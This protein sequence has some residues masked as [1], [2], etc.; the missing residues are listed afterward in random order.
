MPIPNLIYGTAWKQDRTADLVYTALRCGFRAIDS[1]AQ[2]QHYHE[3]GAGHG[4]RRA[5]AE[6]LVRR[7]HVFI[8]T[9]FTPAESQR[10]TAP[11]DL[12]AP[13]VDMVRQSV[14]SSLRSFTVPGQEPYLDSLFLHTP[15]K[16][17]Q[18]TVTVWRTLE[19]YVPHQIRSLGICNVTLDVIRALH[20]GMTVK[21][22]FVQNPLDK[23]RG[24]DADLRRFCRQRDMVF[25]SFWTLTANTDL[26]QSQVVRHVAQMA[27]V[28]LVPAY[29]SLVLG[30]GAIAIL[31]GTTQEENMMSDLQGVEKVSAWA[32]GAEGSLIWQAALVDFKKLVGDA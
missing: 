24:F 1:A 31:D 29:F 16:D 28:Q 17:L 27:G 22:S 9:K 8:Q 2:P 23:H 25:Q 4:L 6:G 3:S 15:M 12:C 30:L 20:H 7:D 32:Q 13:L 14:G 5:V 19:S 11:Y 26:A 21:P 10:H 18:D